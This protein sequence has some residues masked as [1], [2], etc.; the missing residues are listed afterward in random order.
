MMS[1][2]GIVALLI[3][4]LIFMDAMLNSPS[5]MAAALGGMLFA[6]GAGWTAIAVRLRRAEIRKPGKNSGQ[7]FAMAALLVSCISLGLFTAGIIIGDGTLMIIGGGFLLIFG[8]LVTF[9]E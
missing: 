9:Q 4:S 3:V 8:G 7:A 6:I 1:T 5:L 2:V